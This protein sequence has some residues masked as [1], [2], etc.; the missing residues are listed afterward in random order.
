MLSHT[1]GYSKDVRGGGGVVA[2]ELEVEVAQQ[3]RKQREQEGKLDH[4]RH[5]DCSSSSKNQSL[6]A[7]AITRIDPPRVRAI[8]RIRHRQKCGLGYRR[9]VEVAPRNSSSDGKQNRPAVYS[10][11]CASGVG[12]FSRILAMIVHTGSVQVFL[13]HVV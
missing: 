6:T 12:S 3:R 7:A 5:L 2:V 11:S 4:Q 1:T 8:F 13:L 9:P 10:N